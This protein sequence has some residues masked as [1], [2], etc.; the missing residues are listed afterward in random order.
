MYIIGLGNGGN[1]IADLF[2]SYE[3]YEVYKIGL[4][5]KQSP[6]SFNLP[7]CKS[8]ESYEEN[9]PD[10]KSFFKEV[11]DEVL[12][13]MVGS[14][15]ITGATLA[16][17]E[18]LKHTNISILYVRPDLNLISQKRLL[19]EKITF[20]ILQ[21]Y[22]RSGLFHKLYLVDNLSMEEIIGEAPITTYHQKINQTIV[23]TMHMINVFK[24]TD[25]IAI[26]NPQTLDINK[27]T[28]FGI[29]DPRTGKETTFYNLKNITSKFF[30]YSMSKN[31][32]EKD[33]KLLQKIKTQVKDNLAENVIGGFGI[34][35]NE[36]TENYAYIETST[37]IL[38][39][40]D[41][42]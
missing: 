24:H 13:V 12:F 21:E 33:G 17:L 40:V 25:P 27:I 30:Y 16:I 19:Q 15:D 29:L 1:R 28:T 22:A 2:A 5:L 41:I 14:S 3:Q 4:D 20:N 35:Q 10:L 23:T 32:I 6:K 31:Q 11:E 7:V 9:C 36:Y 34:Y 42:A 38:Q 37:H 26:T 39:N 18:Q 8:P